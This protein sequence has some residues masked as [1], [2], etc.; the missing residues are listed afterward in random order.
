MKNPVNP[1]NKATDA[2]HLYKNR[3]T[4]LQMFRAVRSGNFKFTLFTYVVMILGVAYTILPT[5]M[6]PDFIPFVGWVDDGILLFLVFQQLRKELGKYNE[7]LDKEQ[8]WVI[9]K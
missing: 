9:T 3:K 6:L 8:K 5:D 2:Y 4:I 1:I 7:K